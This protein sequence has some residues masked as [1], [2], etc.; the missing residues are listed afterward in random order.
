MIELKHISDYDGGL[1]NDQ[2]YPLVRNHD[3]SPL[4][5]ILFEFLFTESIVPMSIVPMVDSTILHLARRDITHNDVLRLDDLAIHREF[6]NGTIIS[7]PI[8][9]EEAFHDTLKRHNNSYETVCLEWLKYTSKKFKSLP[10][11]EEL[12]T[13]KTWF[14]LKNLDN[15][16]YIAEMPF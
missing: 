10:T 16:N 7:T 13:I 9:R 3:G 12:Q 2:Y 14:D 8:T 4:Y 5:S 11:I 15:D 1:L 6:F